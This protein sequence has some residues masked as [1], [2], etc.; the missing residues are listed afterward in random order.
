[1]REK[2]SEKSEM[3]ELAF[4]SDMMQRVIAP[5]GTA[6]SKGERLRLAQQKLRW[7]HSRTRDV[8][9]G[10]TRVS[11]KPRELRQVEEISGVQ[12][13]QQELAELTALIVRADTILAGSDANFDR[14]FADAIRAFVGAFHRT[15]T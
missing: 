12:Y 5:P 13:G 7:T 6:A 9:Y 15:G 11:I 4:C 3:S 10:D 1:M 2:L 14:P 8:W